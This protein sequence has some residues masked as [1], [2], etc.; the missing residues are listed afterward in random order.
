[1]IE[2]VEKLSA[3]FEGPRFKDREKLCE[4]KVQINL[5]RAP[6]A[7]SSD[8]PYIRASGAGSR[9]STGTWNGLACQHNPSS[10][11]C[12]VEKITGKRVLGRVFTIHS[13]DQTWSSQWVCSVRQS[14]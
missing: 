4:R 10:K 13:R 14:I 3:K 6:Q 11:N 2:Q 7:V 8:I 12:W 9:D 5:S 1:M